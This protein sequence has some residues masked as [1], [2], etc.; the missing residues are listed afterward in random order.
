MEKYF[1][2]FLYVANCGTHWFLLRFPRGVLPLR[3]AKRYC[4]GQ[5]VTAMA[6]GDF[7]VLSFA[8]EDESGDGWDDDGTGY[9]ASLIPLR[10]D[11]AAGDYRALY[12]GWL[13]CVQEGELGS[14]AP[15][16]PVPPGLENPNGPLA[17]LTDFLRID[18]DLIT[19]AIERSREGGAN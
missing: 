16:P 1:D 5:S 7:V 4:R 2:A 15:E 9:L 14:G 8:S 12:L 18:L 13:L 17:A 11:I 19:A 6:K 3:T 10:T